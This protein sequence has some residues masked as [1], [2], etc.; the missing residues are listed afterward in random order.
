VLWPF[1]G[2]A[3]VAAGFSIWGQIYKPESNFLTG[4][5]LALIAKQTA[6]V[7]VGALGMTVVIAS[8]GID[9]SVGS[10]LALSSV[11]LAWCLGH[12]AS[13]VLALAAALACGALCG[14]LNGVLV[15]ALRL[16]P[17]I[18]TLGT[19]LVFRGLAEEL[20]GQKKIQAEAPG[21]MSTLLDPPAAESWRLVCTGVWIVAFLALLLGLVLSRTVFGRH[22]F[23]VGSSEPTARLCGVPVERTKLAVYALGGL[24]TGLAGLFEFDNLNRQGNPTSGVGLEL[25]VI[26][27]VVIGG[28]SL[29]GGKGSVIGSLIGALLMTT[30]RSACVF[31]EV[32]DPVQKLVIG[33]IIVG[34]VALDRM[35][36]RRGRP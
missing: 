8:G 6:I 16:A 36:E 11:V 12:G 17:F 24:C 4:F 9:L 23:A 10:V 29:S 22:V 28:A 33:A 20:S 35:R 32:P 34:A 13:P 5:R 26:A 30:L 7:G 15:T 25:E 1:L 14:L 19:M 18:A 27:A 31:A 3:L 2:L 21:W